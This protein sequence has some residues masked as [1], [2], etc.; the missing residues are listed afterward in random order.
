MT[1]HFECCSQVSMPI[2]A[3]LDRQAACLTCWEHWACC[4]PQ[5]ASTCSAVSSDCRAA[6]LLLPG[7]QPAMA[8]SSCGDDASRQAARRWSRAGLHGGASAASCSRR[9]DTASAVCRRSRACSQNVHEGWSREAKYL[10]L[11]QRNTSWHHVQVTL[12]HL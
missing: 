5:V 3:C 4:V 8:Y 11:H 2:Q 1:M 9:H 12:A 6:G 7:G 10:Q